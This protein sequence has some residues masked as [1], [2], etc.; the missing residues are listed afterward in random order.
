[1]QIEMQVLCRW[2]KRFIETHIARHIETHKTS[3]EWED[4][5]QSESDSDVKQLPGC[6]HASWS[7]S[8]GECDTCRR[9][10]RPL[11]NF[12]IWSWLFWRRLLNLL[13]GIFPRP[14]FENSQTLFFVRFKYCSISITQ[15][16]WDTCDFSLMHGWPRSVMSSNLP[17]SRRLF[18]FQKLAYVTNVASYC[19]RY[20]PDV[21]SHK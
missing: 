15:W 21:A 12:R 5:P 11:V 16:P 8:H 14:A 4:G 17:W 2:H 10:F 18:F 6:Y 13:H 20:F 3:K 19:T 7:T 1:M 9:L